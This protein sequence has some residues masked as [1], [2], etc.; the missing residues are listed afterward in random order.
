MAV[1]SLAL[2]APADA[3]GHW[4]SAL[5]LKARFNRDWW[6]DD[7]YCFALALDPQKRPVRAVTSNVGHCLATG[8]IDSEHLYPVV[9]RLF[10]PDM[11]SG[12]GIRTLSSDH[13]Y[14]D[15]L[16]YHRGSVWAVEQGTI[17]FGL[18]RFGFTARAAELAH[19]MFELAELY[20]DYRIPEC[21]GGYARSER[22]TPGAYPRANTPQL[23]NATMFP[24]VVQSLLGLLPL[25]PINTLVLD[26]TLPEWLPSLVLR[27]L[28]VGDARMTLSFVRRRDGA[29]DWDVVHQQGT[30]HIVRQ[31]PPEST[32]AS[33]ADRARALVES[34][35]R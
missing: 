24:L 15:P 31:P 12:W 22:P 10:A 18:R 20:P 35:T 33:V 4:R 27:D 2:G 21:V 13:A 28:R 3:R 26:P 11:F 1:M 8:I 14:Y 17:V 16:S 23:W 5:A 19:A 32:T 9:G 7:E 34:L 29:T 6:I 30:V 25:A